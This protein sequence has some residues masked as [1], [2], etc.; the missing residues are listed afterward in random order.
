MLIISLLCI[1]GLV[2]SNT[3]C[4]LAVGKLICNR[5]QTRVVGAVVE[6]WEKDGPRHIK[7]LD[8]LLPDQKAGSTIVVNTDGVFKAAGCGWDY[9]WVGAIHLNRPEFYLYI[10]H[11]CNFDEV[12]AI[13]MYPPDMKVFAPKI[14]DYYLD[15]P[16]VLDNTRWVLY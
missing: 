11:R 1:V 7:F 12:E 6:I 13:E 9:D 14:M 8:N 5:N 16:I 4:I 2:A 3:E 10:K 15:H